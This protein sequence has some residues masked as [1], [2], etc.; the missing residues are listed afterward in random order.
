MIVLITGFQGYIGENL[1]YYLSNKGYDVYGVDKQSHF[2]LSVADLGFFKEADVIVHLAGISGIKECEVA[3]KSDRDNIIAS[4]NV[5]NFAHENKIQLIFTSSQAAK[6]PHSSRYAFQKYIT[7]SSV[8][9]LLDKSLVYRLSNVYGG[10]GYLEKKNSVVAKFMKSKERGETAIINGDGTQT[11]DFIHVNDVCR[12]I[13]MGFGKSYHKPIDIGTGKQ[14]S[15]LELA[16][17][18]GV[19]Y[20]INKES[21]MVGISSN[22]ADTKTAKEVLGFEAEE[23]GL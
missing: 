7:E 20:I 21:D 17:K 15:I 5:I 9:S 6:N 11:R 8:L 1:Y 18:I 10:L 13:E 4:C 19:D 23:S 12:A 2:D 14:T 16:E 22:I 3:Y